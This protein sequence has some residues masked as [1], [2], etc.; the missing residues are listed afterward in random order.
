M[1]VL[2]DPGGVPVDR[3]LDRCQGPPIELS[4][5]LRIAFG[6]TTALGQVHRRGLIHKD[7]KPANILVDAESGSAWLT[8]FGIASRL[9]RERQ[10]PDTPDAIAGTLPYMAPEQPART[11][12]TID[13]RTAFYAWR[14][15]FYEM[16]A[17]TL[18][19]KAKDPPR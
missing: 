7:I 18:P 14:A 19:F 8:G 13:A 12:R 1:L 2:E 9:P 5:F 10:A 4:R 17:C 15:T 11:T 16:L 3:I 6:V